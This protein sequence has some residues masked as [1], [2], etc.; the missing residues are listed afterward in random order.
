[1]AAHS[2]RACLLFG[3]CLRGER[4]LG[5]RMPCAEFGARLWLVLV[6]V[7]LTLLALTLTAP[8]SVTASH[9][10]TLQ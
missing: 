1:M 4:A 6:E 9:V 2:Q 5:I 10:L 3:S 7:A 8:T